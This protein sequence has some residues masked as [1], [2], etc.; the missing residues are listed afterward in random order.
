MLRYGG[1]VGTGFTEA[2]LATL[3]P[4]LKAL[5]IG[6]CP[7]DPRPTPTQLRHQRPH[8]VQPS[9]VCEVEFAEWTHEGIVRHASYIGLREDKPSADV[10]REPSA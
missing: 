1:G 5:T 6:E 3:T 4:R 10:V 9:L 8:W 7:F 2:T